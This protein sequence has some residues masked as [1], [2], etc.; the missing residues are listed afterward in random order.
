MA[1]PKVS[2]LTPIYNTDVCHLREC[3]ESVLNQTFSDFE[4]IILNDSPENKALDALVASFD[5]TRIRYVK[6]D[7]TWEFLH[8]ATNCWGWRVGNTSQFS[9]MTISV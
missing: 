4:F 7:K 6:N 5:D 2:V 9:T 1:T 3:I 8:P